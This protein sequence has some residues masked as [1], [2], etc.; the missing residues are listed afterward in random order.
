MSQGLEDRFF[1]FAKRVS[2][3]CE[4]LSFDIINTQY[5]GQLIRAG[6]SIGANYIEASDSL[7]ENDEKMKLRISRREQ[8]NCLLVKTPADC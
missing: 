1:N 4:Q 5:I 2:D 6:S 7:G 3:F 8:R